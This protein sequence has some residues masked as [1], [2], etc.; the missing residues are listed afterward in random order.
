MKTTLIKLFVCFLAAIAL[1]LASFAAENKAPQPG[2]EAGTE[3]SKSVSAKGSK[4]PYHGTIGAVDVAAKTFTI[5][6][7]QKD[8]VIYLTDST[9]ITKE[10]VVA[11]MG[12]LA[13]GEGVRGQ[14]TRKGDQ[15]EAASVMLGAKSNTGK[16]KQP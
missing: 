11:D 14:L 13:A 16:A 3:A 2:N 1:P 6:G 9:K 15:W 12:A 5:K 8:R 4:V 10:G 7:K